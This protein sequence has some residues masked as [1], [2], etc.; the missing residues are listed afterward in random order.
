METRDVNT[1]YK[2]KQLNEITKVIYYGKFLKQI[3]SIT[4]SIKPHSRHQYKQN[5]HINKKYV[6]IHNNE[7]RNVIIIMIIMIYNNIIII[8]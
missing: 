5:G 4:R 8:I 2:D 1:H 3:G 7:E 6:Y